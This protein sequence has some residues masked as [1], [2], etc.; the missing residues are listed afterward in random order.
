MSSG[1]PSGKRG[2][3]SQAEDAHLLKLVEEN[4]ANNWVR[5]AGQLRSRTAK[6]CRERF[7]QNLKPTLN[8]DPITPEE[9]EKIETLVKQMG[10]RWAEIARQ[11]PGRS[12]N[13][14]KNWWNGGMNRRKRLMVRREDSGLDPAIVD[15]RRLEISYV[16][17]AP[18]FNRHLSVATHQ[19]QYRGYDQPLISPAHSEVSMPDSLGEAPS[20][21]SDRGSH[22]TSSPPGAYHIQRHLPVPSGVPGYQ[23]HDTWRPAYVHQ[24]YADPVHIAYDRPPTVWAPQQQDVYKYSDDIYGQRIAPSH[25]LEQFANVAAS[26]PEAGR[27]QLDQYQRQP[28]YPTQV[29]YP[30]QRQSLYP[31]QRPL[32]PG[33][34]DLPQELPSFNS[35][36]QN[37]AERT[38]S[39]PSLPTPVHQTSTLQ[40]PLSYLSS[41]T[42]EHPRSISLED[43][44]RS[45]PPYEN[46]MPP[47]ATQIPLSTT[48]PSILAQT[49]TCA[50]DSRHHSAEITRPGSPSKVPLSGILN[51]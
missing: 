45:E 26:R 34:R 6:Q 14:V 19:P 21:M 40:H 41:Q 13:A 10:K 12:D 33:Q 17:P 47:P 16:R 46:S 44:K 4:G 29:H 30:P 36:V 18:A 1:H 8:H 51:Q 42:T 24:N 23:S 50:Q 2:P 25:R 43:P 49:P 9:G 5:I 28:S 22:Y 38:I 37:N 32:P 7:H 11:L 31:R 39:R 3:W 27:I 48:A 15:D 20:L 35:F